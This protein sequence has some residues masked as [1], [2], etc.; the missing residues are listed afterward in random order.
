MLI[1]MDEQQEIAEYLEKVIPKFDTLEQKL[2]KEIELLR[3]M[4]IR[5]ISDVVTG[6]IDIRS[7]TIPDYQILDESELEED[8][9][10][11]SDEETEE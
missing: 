3:E 7:V 2:L 6:A 10:D 11:V 9:L 1:P 8:S 5:L 4:K